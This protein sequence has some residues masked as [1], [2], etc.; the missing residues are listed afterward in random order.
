MGNK[1]KIGVKQ[2]EEVRT[3]WFDAKPI[4]YLPFFIFIFLGLLLFD[5]KIAIGGDDAE[6]IVSAKKFLDGVSFPGWHGSFYPI[7][8]SLP[9]ALFGINVILFK[10]ISFLLIFI[11]LVFFYMAFK[12]R[13]KPVILLFCLFLMS[14]NY[15]IL[16]NACQTSSESLYMAIQSVAL[17]F[18]IRLEESDDLSWKS[19]WR[20]WILFGLM[21]FLI[22]QTRNIGYAFLIAVICYFLIHKKFGKIA[23][24]IIGFLIFFIPYN[25]YK[26]L[27]WGSKNIGIESQ[28]KVMFYKDPYNQAL[29]FENLGSFIERFFNNTNY[30]LSNSIVKILGFRSIDNQNTSWLITIVIIAFFLY[31][32]YISFKNNKNLFFIT[33]YTGFTLAVT[34]ITQQEGW[35]QSRLILIILPVFLLML[36]SIIDNLKIAE[37]SYNK[38]VLIFVAIILFISSFKITVNEIGKNMNS[39]EKNLNRDKLFGY[40]SDYK[41]Y[42]Q[43]SKWIGKN[44][45]KDKIIG[46][47]KPDLSYIYSNGSNFVGIYKTTNNS[48]NDIHFSYPNTILID[49]LSYLKFSPYEYYAGFRKY[50]VSYV[51]W[52]GGWYILFSIPDKDLNDFKAVL[53][54]LKLTYEEDYNVFVEQLKNKGINAYSLYPDSVVEFFQKRKIDYLIYASL[55]LNPDKKDGLLQNAVERMADY[56]NL[57]YPEFYKTI[58]KFGDD[59]DEPASLIQ[60]N[61][62]VI[63]RYSEIPPNVNLN[64]N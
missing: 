60:L 20:E 46:C 5:V 9:C 62:D 63:K 53:K 4:Y 55:R 24:S 38:R 31:S 27:I 61:Y 2:K 15:F 28:F 40:T 3:K 6:Y 16:N 57:R 29:G 43:V 19:N 50:F 59:N 54:E 10:F 18:F 42:I 14:V 44:I 64:H 26:Y 12:K 13:I 49:V 51:I 41:N 39:L 48:V 36:F 7:F 8:L 1:R 33:I 52:D 17:F 21:V 47:R 56:V 22:S 23:L 30:Y 58:V 34:F 25:A 32:L 35:R 45:E 11:H 37:G